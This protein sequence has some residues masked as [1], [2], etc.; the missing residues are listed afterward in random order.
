M[1]LETLIT[2][3]TFSLFYLILELVKRKMKIS[4]HITR[5]IAH[6]TSALLSIV[7]Y[8]FLSKTTF[9]L[10]TTIFT[11]V[12]CISYMTHFFT[13]VHITTHKTIGEIMYPLS[14]IILA[15]LFFDTQFIMI[16]AIAIMGFSDA[17]T[18]LYNHKFKKN[19]L[20]G[21]ILFFLLTLLIIMTMHLLYFDNMS[22]TILWQI[23]A[24]SLLTSVVEHYSNYGLDNLTVPLC[25]AGLLSIF[26]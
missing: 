3:V 11:I 15:I 6:I 22:T 26:F 7:F 9:I 16:T 23:G 10:V 18:G 14:L 8:L 13:S 12:F 19:T 5:K 2:I 1:M 25:A 4:T 24:V 17:I 21:S 20:C